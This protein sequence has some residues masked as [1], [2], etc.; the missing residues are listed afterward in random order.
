MKIF[1]TILLAAG[2]SAFILPGQAQDASVNVEQT[3]QQKGS[4]HFGLTTALNNTWIKVDN[5]EPNNEHFKYKTTFHWAPV[6]AVV[7][8]KFN[9]RHDVQ[10]EAF[11]SRQGQ[12]Y[13]ITE[14][15]D[16]SGVELGEKRINLTYLQIPLLFKFT[17]G[18]ATRFNLHVGPQ[19][20]FLIKGEEVN[21]FPEAI[22]LRDRTL[23]GTYTLAKKEKSDPL[24]KPAGGF[25]SIAPMAVL[26]FGIEK[27]ITDKLYL[28]GNLRFNYGFTDI[29]DTEITR[30]NFDFDRYFLRYNIFGGIQAGIHYTLNK[31]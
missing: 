30:S 6:G 12:N 5:D 17:T 3:R 9:D 21:E 14:N 20:G 28:S 7:G 4:F 29:R 19:I 15:G 10:L 8:Y 27:D 22:T 11:L 2:V 1:K 13:T 26:G 18:D 24:F 16:G 31:S 25:N 23:M